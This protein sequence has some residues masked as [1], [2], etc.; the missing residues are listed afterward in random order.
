MEH[1]KVDVVETMSLAHHSLHTQLREPAAASPLRVALIGCGAIAEQMHLPVLAG[2][3]GLKLTVLVDRDGKRAVRFAKGYGV[4]HVLNDAALL[5]TELVDAAIIATP[6]FHHAPCAIELMRRGVHVLVEKP[7][8]TCYADA[9]QMV[10]AAEAA[11]VVLSVGFFRRLNP[12]I[13]LL[14][15]LLESGWAGPP[16]GFRVEG[17][18]IYGWAAATL[19]NM[20]KELAG[21]GVLIDFGSHMLDLLF[22]LFDEPADVLEYR[23]NCLGGV[24]ADCSVRAR[25]EHRGKPIEGAIELARTRELDSF[26]QIVC[27]RA[28]LEFHVGERHRIRIIPR[29]VRLV[30]PLDVAHFPMAMAGTPPRQPTHKA[31]GAGWWLEALWQGATEDESWYAT[32]GRQFDDWLEAIRTGSTPVLSGRSA[33]RTAKFIEDCY[34]ARQPMREPWVFAKGSAVSEQRLGA[35]ARLGQPKRERNGFHLTHEQNEFR[36][37]SSGQPPSRNG[38][39]NHAEAELERRPLGDTHKRVLV[40]GAS[41]FIG[42]RVAEILRL[43]ENC[44]VRTLVHNPGNASRLARLDVEMVQADL[45]SPDDAR[46][47]VEDCDAIVH[48]AIGTEWGEPR[49]IFKVTVDGTRHLAEAALKAGARRFVHLSTMSVYGDDGSLVG[50]LDER[51]PARPASG[52]VYGQSKAAAERALFR[53]AGQGLPAVVLRPA[54]VFGPFSR[55]FVTRPIQAIADGRFRWLGSPDVPCDMVYVDNVVEA[56]L[57]SLRAPADAVAGEAFNVSDGHDMTWR[58]FYEFFTDRLRLDLAQVPVRPGREGCGGRV[59]SWISPVSWLRAAGQIVTSPEFKSLGRRVLQ[60]DPV[61][62]LP[63]WALRRF[64][65]LQRGVRRLVGADESLPVHRPSAAAAG[66][67][68]EMGSAGA[69][70]SIDKAQRLMRYAAPVARD[71]ALRLTLEWVEHARLA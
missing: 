1:C 28:T 32:F 70:L 7:M 44:Q 57:C 49:K 68:V 66:H 27:Q 14:K 51:M 2:H 18:G 8:A 12:S 26:V 62:T 13:R 50:L 39:A 22:A 52:S 61:G 43:Y 63:R 60:T 41:G 45:A 53:L 69:T 46:R 58:Q 54:R 15:A 5:S 36:S 37:T 65:R 30:D 56:I 21:G 42:C 20:K 59:R 34:A 16:E 71:E 25:L 6:P 31:G 24:E 33:L 67:V 19:G 4:E 48:C 40:T 47:V 23:D 55:I 29:D 10:E 9:L 11:D 35:Y 38:H 17:G 3:D 64:P